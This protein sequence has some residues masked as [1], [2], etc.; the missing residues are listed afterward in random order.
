MMSLRRDDHIRRCTY[1]AIH[2]QAELRGR[3][4]TNKKCN[5]R[6][7]GGWAK[8]IHDDPFGKDLLSTLM[9]L[10]NAKKA[11]TFLR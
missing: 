5:I 1:P 10:K 7:K 4:S 6:R 9:A 3:S 11:I 2:K 8:V